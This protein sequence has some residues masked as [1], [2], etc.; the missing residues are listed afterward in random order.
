[1]LAGYLRGIAILIVPLLL[2]AGAAAKSGTCPS[3]FESGGVRMKRN[4]HFDL[5]WRDRVPY[6]DVRG[7]V[8]CS[9]ESGGRLSSCSSSIADPRGAALS[10][11]VSRWRVLS[12]VSHGCRLAGRKIRF[13]FRL[14]LVDE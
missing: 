13:L 8:I 3:V 9:V 1:M 10:K 6:P 4:L 7:A 5:P 12:R 11:Q 14:Q 2:S